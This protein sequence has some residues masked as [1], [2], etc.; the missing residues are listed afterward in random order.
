M[1]HKLY[2]G[3]LYW[4]VTR[5]HLRELFSYYGTVRKIDLIGGTGYGFV[6]MSDEEEAEKAWKALD[7][8]GFKERV[9][10]V[11]PAVPPGPFTGSDMKKIFE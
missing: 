2:V 4:N 9:I 8:S 3:N 7:G 11:R 6:E 10:R 5:D 1:S